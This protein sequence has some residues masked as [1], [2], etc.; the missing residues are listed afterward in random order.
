MFSQLI[1][2]YAS[3]H[4]YSKAGRTLFFLAGSTFFFLFFWFL[5]TGVIFLEEEFFLYLFRTSFCLHDRQNEMLRIEKKATKRSLS[6]CKASFT[7][8]RLSKRI[9]I[10]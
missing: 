10:Q 4:I 1:S 3:K 8:V 6:H 2:L 7:I 9:E 5:L